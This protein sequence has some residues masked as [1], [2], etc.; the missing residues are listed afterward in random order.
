[1]SMIMPTLFLFNYKRNMNSNSYC[2]CKIV[3]YNKNS[4]IN[5]LKF[6]LFKKMVSLLVL[7]QVF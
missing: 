5:N 7:S 4:K 2:L 1:M 3:K 6:F